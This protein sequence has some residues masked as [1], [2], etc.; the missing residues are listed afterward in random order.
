[1]SGP[2]AAV[3]VATHYEDRSD[4]FEL[5]EDGEVADVTGVNDGVGALEGSEGFRAKQTVGVRDD[6]EKKRIHLYPMIAA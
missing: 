4:G 3:G 6:A 5:I 1:L 2:V